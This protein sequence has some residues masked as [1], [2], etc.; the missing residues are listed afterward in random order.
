MGSRDRIFVAVYYEIREFR[1]FD[2]KDNNLKLF[3]DNNE[4]GCSAL[5][6]LLRI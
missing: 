6:I 1:V 5:L 2:V 4:F 3:V